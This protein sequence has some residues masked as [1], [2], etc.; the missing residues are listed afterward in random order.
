MPETVRLQIYSLE[1]K[2][3]LRSESEEQILTGKGRENRIAQIRG[4]ERS[5]GQKEKL[6]A[7]FTSAYFISMPQAGKLRL[8]M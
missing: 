2:L 3:Q 1:V 6:S 8:G 5:G 7:Y 4:R